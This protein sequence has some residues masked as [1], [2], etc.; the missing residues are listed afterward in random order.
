VINPFFQAD[1]QTDFIGCESIGLGLHAC[2][3]IIQQHKGTIR[4]EANQGEGC[5]VHVRWPAG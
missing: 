4:M 3:T 5:T 2:R 1:A